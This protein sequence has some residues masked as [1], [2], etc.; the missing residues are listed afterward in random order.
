M[1]NKK[2]VGI[3]IAILVLALVACLFYKRNITGSHFSET[4]SNYYAE[5]GNTGNVIEPEYDFDSEHGLGE[6]DADWFSKYYGL[7]QGNLPCADCS[8]IFTTLTLKADNQYDFSQHYRKSQNP[9][10][11]Y[12]DKENLFTSSGTYI[13][14]GDQLI[15]TNTENKEKTFL[16]ILENSFLMLNKKGEEPLAELR[17]DY[18]LKKFQDNE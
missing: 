18:L 14:K 4:T 17:N 10:D 16:K 12:K 7:Y 9:A 8:S 13:T 5:Y 6:T 11:Y 15:L 2:I 3:V 1:N